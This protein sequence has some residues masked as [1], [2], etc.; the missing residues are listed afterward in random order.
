[1]LKW[2][3]YSTVVFTV[4]LIF[5]Q[6]P[7]D[8]EKRLSNSEIDL[9]KNELKSSQKKDSESFEFQNKTSLDQKNSMEVVSIDKPNLDD[10][11]ETED[12]DI[13]FGYNFFKNEAQFFDNVPTP[14]NYRL[15]PGD[16]ITLYL[17]GETNLQKK[18]EINKE[19]I[20]FYENVG[21][22]NLSNLT[23]SEAENLLTNKL[24]TIYS[25]LSSNEKKTTLMLEVGKLKS[26]NVYFTGQVEKPGINLIHPFSD[27][28][29]ALVQAG[30]IKESGSLRTVQL[31][32]DGKVIEVIDFY[33]F[34]I[35]GISDFQKRKI[36]NGDVIN[37]PVIGSRV[38]VE[39]QVSQPA[40]YEAIEG[41]SLKDLIFYA[42]GLSSNASSKVIFST[43]DPQ[44]RRLSDDEAKTSFV[45][46][47]NDSQNVTL[48][49]G[50][51]VN[52]MPIIENDTEVDVIG[53]V[54][55][56]GKY[57]AFTFSFQN[58]SIAQPSSLKDVLDLAGGF[59]DMIFRKSINEDIVILRMDE[60][61]FYAK[62]L[63]VNY[64]NAQDFLLE[65]NDKIFVYKMNNYQ[66]SFYYSIDGEVNKPGAYPL[67]VGLTLK[68][69]IELAGGISELG[70]INSLSVASQRTSRDDEGK[71]IVTN[72]L[73][74]NINLSYPISH[75]DK[76]E[77]LPKSSV[78]RVAGNVYRPGLVS[79]DGDSMT[80]AYAIELAGGY[81]PNTLKKRSYV[82]RSNG[83]IEKANL[84]RGLAKRVY[85]G[86]S[87]F[88][89]LDPN[90]DKF[91]ITSFIGDLSTT[92][93]NIAA[94]LILVDNQNN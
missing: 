41:D 34:F 3:K 26:I 17:W 62:E 14:S 50:S 20:I 11:V 87:I 55:K 2:I 94:I 65:V 90:P 35:S 36:I 16:Q 4:S 7:S 42:G 64:K 13:F 10:K 28:F 12:V 27:V 24:S 81:K 5:S 39:G 30:G 59:D 6:I 91:N 86:D 92:L 49:N 18:F 56:P 19:G 61:Q 31:I 38:L 88:V 1:M 43:I 89:P 48:D 22:L 80:M 67:R 71:Q 74:G 79:H 60:N 44:N 8:L 9:I 58:K 33:S 73:V 21:Y 53:N 75:L 57:P 69:A 54:K 46:N 77:I 51:Y 85:P 76:I 32:R 45:L 23:V 82:V 15:G 70:S 78:I 40:Y 63:I 47:L 93:A 83:E 68:E 25:T 84:F 66:N 29:A 72:E 37:I 52:V